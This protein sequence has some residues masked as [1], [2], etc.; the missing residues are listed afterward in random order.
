MAR[1]SESPGFA[2]AFRDLLIALLVVFMALAALA[3]VAATKAEKAGVTQGNLVFT[4]SWRGTGPSGSA[5]KADV[6][7]WVKAP[8]DAPVGFSHMS[9]AH[10][11]LLRDDLGSTLDP[12]S[13]AQEMVVCRGL[14]SGEWIVDAMLYQAHGAALPVKVTATAMRLGAGGVTTFLEQSGLLRHRGEQL[15]MFRFRFARGHFLPG[16]VNRLPM[17]LYGM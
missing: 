2:W 17:K 16:S 11:N 3:L 6:D 13:T 14:P 10:C 15:T 1:R 12:Q 8:G 7:L 4:L 9:D 5:R